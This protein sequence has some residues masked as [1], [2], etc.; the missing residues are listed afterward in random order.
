[1]EQKKFTTVHLSAMTI[2]NI[3][4]LIDKTIEIAE[5]VKSAMTPLAEKAFDIVKIDNIEFE[6]RMKKNMA[7]PL[8]QELNEIDKERK[9]Q[10]SEIKRYITNASKSSI[11][12]MKLGGTRLNEF[13]KPYWDTNKKSLN[14]M[15]SLLEEMFVRFKSSTSLQ[16]DAKT[17]GIEIQ[18]KLLEGI[19]IKYDTAYKKRNTETGAKI[20]NTASEMKEQVIKSYEQFCVI[21]EQSVNLMPSPEIQKLFQEME[22]LR[23]KYALL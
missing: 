18:M 14:T 22:M 12:T 3:Y 17:I 1:M 8:T 2:D 16:A 9:N 10:F 13:M 21:I 5:P 6:S 19:N 4:G 7:S 11:T 20:G 23:K 15:T